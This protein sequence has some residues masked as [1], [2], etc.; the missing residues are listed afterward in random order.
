MD[1]FTCVVRKIV[2]L[3]V[4]VKLY[5][6][7]S[8]PKSP[9]LQCRRILVRERILI[10]RAPSWIRT[11]EMLG[12][13]AKKSESSFFRLHPLRLR[14]Q[15]QT[16]KQNYPTLARQ[17]RQHCRQATRARVTSV[18]TL[19]CRYSWCWPK[20]PRRLETRSTLWICLYIKRP[21]IPT[22]QRKAMQAVSVCRCRLR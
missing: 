6:S 11:R 5:L 22:R 10:G 1:I 3:H 16:R 19:G 12:E 9:S 15:G 17:K 4:S 7:Q 20:R 18:R 13:R 14:L 2:S 8:R 21:L